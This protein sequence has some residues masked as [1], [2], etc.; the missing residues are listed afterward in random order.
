MFSISIVITGER[1]GGFVLAG[2]VEI[3]A[4]D[5]IYVRGVAR[6]K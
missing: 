3:K 2:Q 5:D 6:V 4:N 1:A